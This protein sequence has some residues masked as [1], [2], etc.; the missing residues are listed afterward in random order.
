MEQPS[1][2]LDPQFPDYVCKLKKSLYCLK[3]S[4][5]MWHFK[6]HTYLVSIGFNSLQAEPNIYIRKDGAI[7][8]IIG[9]YV[10][11]LPIASNSIASIRKTINQLKEKFLVKDLGPLEYCLGIKVT[12]NHIEGTLTLT[13]QKL[14]DDILQK[15]EM[16]DCKPISTPMT[17]PCKLSTND[18]PMSIEEEQIRKSLPYRQ[19]LGSIRYLVSCTRPD[20]SYCAGFLSRFM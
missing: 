11:D 8:V 1:H 13:Q 18:S 16:V 4:P 17:V 6:L 12:R 2:F 5:Q 3:Q 7:Y 19:I 14:V 20:L 10:D 9:V 15:F